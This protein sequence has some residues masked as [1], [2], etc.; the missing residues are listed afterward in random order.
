[1]Y[2]AAGTG[3][4]QDATMRLI[5][6]DHAAEVDEEQVDSDAVEGADNLFETLRQIVNGR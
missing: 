6:F 1:M 5:D 4:E 2:D 3:T